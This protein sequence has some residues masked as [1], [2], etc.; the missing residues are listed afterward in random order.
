LILGFL[1]GLAL[2]PSQTRSVAAHPLGN[3]TINLYSHVTVEREKV[4][5]IYVVDKAEIPT[6]Q[7]FGATV[8]AGEA[9][10]VYL[11][12]AA[13]SLLNGLRLRVDQQAV[14]MEVAS[15]ALSFPPG[16]GGLPTTRIELQVVANVPPVAIGEQHQIDYEDTNFGDRL[17]WREIV[18][19]AGSGVRITQS[20]AA[21]EDRSDALQTYPQD[22]L[23]SPPDQRRA[24]IEIVGA[25]ATNAQVTANGVS[26]TAQAT[27]GTDRLAALI[28]T[29]QLGPWVIL[30][31]LLA[32]TGL[33]AVHALSP[34]HGKAIVAGYLVGARGT[35]R[36]AFFLGLTVT[37]TH[38]L[39]VFTLGLIT[40]YASRYILPE[41]LYPWL[42]VLSGLL[43]VLMGIM[44][45]RQRLQALLAGR[46]GASGD[47]EPGAV[48]LHHHGFGLVHE[49]GPNTHTHLPRSVRGSRVTWKSLLVLGISGGL[50]P[51]PSALVVLLS[52]IA[53]GRVGFGLLLIVAFSVGLAGSLTGIGLLFVYGTRWIQR[54]GDRPLGGYAA[55]VI[56][57]A[58]AAFVT[59]AGLIITGRA[60][61]EA[62]LWKW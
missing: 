15:H 41:Q 14:Q 9:Q 30:L 54:L 53:L 56:P 42:G 24:Q 62:G 26:E 59:V 33:G 34:G 1:L 18:V 43:V 17:G 48:Q 28:A 12:T 21:S 16:Q 35:A 11:D 37:I 25:P 52:A 55:R 23:Q 5:I 31:A 19:A 3:F 22:M 60:L 27:E 44:L 46:R 20:D 61:A 7:E 58:S 57:L 47:G 36:H 6:F 50:L 51:C 8:P 38:T 29:E 39:G 2:L 40:L 45:G 32:A 13:S 4:S 10:A 49:H